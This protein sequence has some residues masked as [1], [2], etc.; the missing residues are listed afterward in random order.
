M[1]LKQRSNKFLSISMKAINSYF[2]LIFFDSLTNL[3]TQD[4]KLLLISYR[5]K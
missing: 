2:W 3:P 4:F 1:L 5:H